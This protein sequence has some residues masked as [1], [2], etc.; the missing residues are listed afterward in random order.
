MS[1]WSLAEPELRKDSAALIPEVGQVRVWRCDRDQGPRIGPDTVL[2]VEDESFVREVTCEVLRAE[3]YRVLA[4]KNAVEAERVY[5]LHGG[6]VGLLLTDVVLPG[7]NGRTLAGRLRQENPRLK[8]LLV[9]GYAEQLGPGETH[10][11][12]LAKPFSASVLMRK[13]R[14][15]F[16]SGEGAAEQRRSA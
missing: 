5:S 8:V 2:L 4:A 11:E 13:V 12:C 1:H 16:E 14:Q 6:D 10:E 7:E 9:T 3:G 15:M